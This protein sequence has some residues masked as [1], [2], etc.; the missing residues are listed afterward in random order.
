MRALTLWLE[1]S[2]ITGGP[3][4]PAIGRWG[5]EVTGKPICD[6]QLAKIIRRLAAQAGL[7]PEVF[8]GHSLRSGLAAS[9]AGGGA[10][11]RSI[12][13]Q[14]RHRSL[15]QVRRYIRRGSLFKENA[16]ARSGL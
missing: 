1:R 16:A 12:M 4:F 11:E 5:R 15:K 9:A 8:S 6:R 14:T 2:G 13:E 7:D 10:S 3:L